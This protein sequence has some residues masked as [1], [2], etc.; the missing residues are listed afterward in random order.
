MDYN[1]LREILV[2]TEALYNLWQ[3]T[4][5]DEEAFIRA[6]GKLIEQTEK[7]RLQK[8]QAK[9]RQ[10]KFFEK[11]KSEGKR[12]LSA[13]VS[14]STYD[15]LCRIRDKSIKSG[16]PK[17]LGDVLDELLTGSQPKQAIV[18]TQ[19]EIP[20]PA[21]TLA[22][23]QAADKPDTIKIIAAHRAAELTWPAIAT[24]LNDKKLFTGRGKKWTPANALTFFNRNY[25]S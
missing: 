16:S 21:Q 7:A 1:Q 25:K 10:V 24:A 18:E 6:N 8:E 12:F 4:G 2:N 9:A 23:D 22:Q 17:N 19:T 14:A 13:M 11:K 20:A 5:L 3:S 15:Q